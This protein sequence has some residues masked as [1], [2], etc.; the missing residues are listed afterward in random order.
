[1]FSTTVCNSLNI[2]K[3][4]LHHYFTSKYQIQA[5]FHVPLKIQNAADYYYKRAW[6]VRQDTP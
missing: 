6:I 4:I 2:W 1:M 5:L 3:Y